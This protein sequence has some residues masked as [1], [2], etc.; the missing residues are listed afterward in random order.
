MVLK[1]FHGHFHDIQ[2]GYKYPKGRRFHLS[3][4]SKIHILVRKK[5]EKSHSAEKCRHGPLSSK[6]VLVEVETQKTLR[7]N[8]NFKIV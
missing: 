6:N 8:E 7:W 2:S 5:I 3:E 4:R 1:H